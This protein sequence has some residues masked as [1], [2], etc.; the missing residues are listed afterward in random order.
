M[1]TFA[2]AAAAAAA[3][4]RESPRGDADLADGLRHRKRR[5]LCSSESSM[6]ASRKITPDVMHAWHARQGHNLLYFSLLAFMTAALRTQ[7]K[8]P[9]FFPPRSLASA[10]SHRSLG[11]RRSKLATSQLLAFPRHTTTFFHHMPLAS[12]SIILVLLLYL[13]SCAAFTGAGF[14]FYPSTTKG[15]TTRAAFGARTEI[16]GTMGVTTPRR[17]SPRR[18]A[19]LSAAS[20]G[21]AE[22]SP[23]KKKSPTRAKSKAKASSPK[24][25]SPARAKKSPSRKNK[26][27]KEPDVKIFASDLANIAPENEW[28]DLHV[29]PEELRP[30]NCLTTGQAFS[31]LVVESDYSDEV[32]GNGPAKLESNLDAE[33]KQEQQHQQ[34]AWGVHDAMEW[35]GPLDN[36][37]ISV[38]ET[39]TTSLYRVLHGPT[40]GVEEY[41]RDYF[42]LDTPLAPLYDEWGKCD[43]RLRRIA[44][45]IPG[46]RILR[47][48]PVE[49]LFSFICS[50]NNNVPRITQLLK[51]FR[52]TYGKFLMDLPCRQLDDEGLPLLG[53]EIVSRK[54][55]SFPSLETLE[56]AT[57]KG[58]R[59]MGFGYRAPYLV[60]TRDLLQELG[61]HDYLMHLRT[62]RDADQVQEKLIEFKGV[63]RKVADC[64]ALFSLDQTEAIPV[65][66]HVWH[67][68]CREYDSTLN[69]V[70]SLTPTVYRR[71]GDLFRS[72]FSSHAGWAHSLLF[73]AELPSFRNA[74]PE[75][76]IAQ[77]NEWREQ[78]QEK[79]AADKEAKKATQAN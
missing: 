7:S 59:E 56:A 6:A 40:D 38:R 36:W 46:V 42:Q 67:I 71:V 70:K 61:G 52:Q 49:C 27:S 43:D 19:A 10:R 41:L 3:D 14:C 2:A 74:L 58:L 66:T 34:S 48:D 45:V 15:S 8:F 64:V 5:S 25:K 77:M 39:P 69:E 35:V 18:S 13:V 29:L 54:I 4:R 23:A 44:E 53:G 21:T 78:E 57:D 22:S 26:K 63:G 17:R 76:I 12:P 1:T 9:G 72:R 50:S 73:V 28:V 30:S 24:R 11:R 68:A 47:Q 51:A 20:A 55:Y 31:W 62:I 16:T 37:V 75:D 60:E 32:G 33:F 79:K 65:D